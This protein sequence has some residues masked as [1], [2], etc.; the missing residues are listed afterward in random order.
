MA[1]RA[2]RARQRDLAE[3]D[4]LVRQRDADQRGDQRRRRREIGGRLADAQ[5][6]GDVEINVVLPSF[7][8]PCASSTA[9]TMASRLESQPTTARRGVPSVVGATSA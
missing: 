2:H 6:A 8:P 3:I 5:A 9:S 1:D 4:R 7:S